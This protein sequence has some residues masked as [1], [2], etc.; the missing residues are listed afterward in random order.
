MKPRKEQHPRP[1]RLGPGLGVGSQGPRKSPAFFAGSQPCFG[2]TPCPARQGSRVLLQGPHPCS[3]QLPNA[4]RGPVTAGPKTNSYKKIK[5]PGVKE[6]GFALPLG[7]F[8]Q[9]LFA[10]VRPPG[11]PK[12]VGAGCGKERRPQP[13]P[14]VRAAAGPLAEGKSPRGLRPGCAAA[15]LGAARLRPFPLNGNSDCRRAGPHTRPLA[16]SSG[17]YRDGW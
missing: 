8:P 3:L 14:R 13:R 12:S 16:G 17:A 2:A 15:A 10:R 9:N 4:A 7:T 5:R 11:P 1:K 6:V